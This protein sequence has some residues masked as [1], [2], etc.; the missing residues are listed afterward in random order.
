MP[1]KTE[2]QRQALGLPARERLALIAELRDSL[3]P[4]DIPVPAWQREL[5][6][7]RLGELDGLDPRE[8]STPWNL[9]RKD[10]FPTGK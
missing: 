8:R 7:D 5:I 1:A 2:I 3:T 9:A 4:E 6:R 10:L